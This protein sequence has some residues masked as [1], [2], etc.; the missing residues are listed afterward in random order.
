MTRTL[1]NQ[2]TSMHNISFHCGVSEEEYLYL[3]KPFPTTHT[4]TQN[5]QFIPPIK[6]SKAYMC[7]YKLNFCLVPSYTANVT[8]ILFTV[9]AK[10]TVVCP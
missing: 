2:Y 10:R 1:T 3:P 9:L 8:V 5:T 7:T 6:N 4:T